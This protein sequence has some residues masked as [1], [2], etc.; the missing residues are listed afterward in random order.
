MAFFDKLNDFAKNIAAKTNEALDETRSKG[1]IAAE[2]SAAREKL[3]AI[4][5][6]MYG[7]YADTGEA[8]PELAPLLEE[9]K[10]HYDAIDEIQA[11]I[12]RAEK[13][14]AAKAITECASCGAVNGSD[15]KFCREC[16]A[17]LFMPEPE[18]EPTGAV[19]PSCGAENVAEAR[20]CRECGSRMNAKP[21][22]V[23]E[24][25]EQQP[26][27][28]IEQ[29]KERVCPVCGAKADGETRFCMECGA[30]LDA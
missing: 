24:T 14:A 16:G 22:A 23:E 20:F 3:A 29:P 15:A 17:K 26:E 9:V 19:C 21:A 10:A 8:D 1:R 12:R 13:R 30:K 7:R 28:E 11:E 18:P 27:E 2:R 25:E 5:E 4:G 6:V